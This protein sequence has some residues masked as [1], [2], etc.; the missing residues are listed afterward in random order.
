MSN[1]A[2]VLEIDDEPVELDLSYDPA[3]GELSDSLSVFM[4]QLGR[5][6]LLT[7]A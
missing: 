3:A 5:Y 2:D 1:A 7:A 4:N 6:P